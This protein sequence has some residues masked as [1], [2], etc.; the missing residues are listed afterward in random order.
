MRVCGCVCITVL[1]QGCYNVTAALDCVHDVA[2]AAV[3]ASREQHFDLVNIGYS[4]VRGH[5][6][7]VRSQ[8]P[9]EA[10]ALSSMQAP[11]STNDWPSLSSARELPLTRESSTGSGAL[12]AGAQPT[13]GQVPSVVLASSIQALGSRVSTSHAALSFPSLGAFIECLFHRRPRNKAV[14][15]H[16]LSSRIQGSRAGP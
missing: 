16:P 5:T 14:V 11:S 3:V 10:Q 8:I 6:Q 2:K 12:P 9:S 13:T 15:A 1:Y 7:R 4:L